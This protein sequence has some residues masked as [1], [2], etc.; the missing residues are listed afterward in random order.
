MLKRARLLRWAILSTS[1]VCRHGRNL[2]LFSS[3][4]RTASAPRSSRPDCARPA[5][6]PD[7]R[8]RRRRHRPPHRRDRPRRHR[9]RSREPQSRHAREHVPAVA[10]GEAA[11]RHVRRSLRPGLDRGG[12]RCRRLGLCRRRSEA[13]ARQADPRHGD[14]PLQRL[15]AHDARARGGALRAREPQ[16]GR[17][18]QGHPDE[19]AR[20]FRRGRLCAAAQDGDEPEPQDR[21]DRRE[22]RH[23]GRSPGTRRRRNER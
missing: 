21:R 18:R 6:Q 10:R 23:G 11:D 1:H 5:M 16:A 19:I 12:G 3:S 4:T 14:Q 17:P 2:F 20:A 8:P 15:L 9:H 22:P 7:R 13:G